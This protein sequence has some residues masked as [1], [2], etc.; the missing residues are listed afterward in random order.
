MISPLIK[1]EQ[2]PKNEVKK[3]KSDNFTETKRGKQNIAIVILEKCTIWF[4][5]L[6]APISFLPTLH[7][8]TK[9]DSTIE[10]H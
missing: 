7:I 4:C 9:R 8:N 10:E 2:I 5:I 3:I 6:G 1:K